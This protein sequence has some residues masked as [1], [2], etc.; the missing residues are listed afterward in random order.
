M[1]RIAFAGAVLLSSLLSVNVMA[2][3]E[4]TP[5]EKAAADIANRQAVF[6]LL[7]VANGALGGMARGAPFDAAAAKLGTEAYMV[8]DATELQESWFEGRTR[9]GLTAGASAPEVLVKAV[10][11][12]IRALGAV[13]VR[14]MEGIEETIKFPLPKGLR[15][16]SEQTLEADGSR[17]HESG[18]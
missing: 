2:A 17:L 5:E 14:K 3:A 10:I 9:V 18:H 4:Q 16:N 6:K 7:S 12:R 15:M 13:S 11:D 1:K 8:D